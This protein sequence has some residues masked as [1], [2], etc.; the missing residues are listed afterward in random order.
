MIAPMT[1]NSVLD[2]TSDDFNG[3]TADVFLTFNNELNYDK[4]VLLVEGL[5]DALFYSEYFVE[6]NVFLFVMNGHEWMTQV[7]GDLS[8]VFPNQLAAIKD[9]DFNHL[10]N[11]YSVHQN[12]FVTD[13]HDW[14]MTI[15]SADRTSRIA[16]RYGICDDESGILHEEVMR[17]LQ[18]YS[19]VR[20]ANSWIPAKED[21]VRFLDD[22]ENMRGKT[23]AEVVTIVNG[24]QKENRWIDP[25][26]VDS[27]KKQHPNADLR[28]LNNCHD[29]MRMLRKLISEKSKKNIRNGEIPEAYVRLFTGADFSLTRLAHNLRSYSF[30]KEVLL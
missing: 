3:K 16:A 20:W 29:Y 11:S 7:L 8:S 2:Y 19:Y 23:L 17:E 15:V 4:V 25:I 13:C 12:M 9:A 24:N 6:E 18:N 1:Q 5:D 10:D 30:T 27:F 28:Q 22:A 14:E 26:Y 21:R